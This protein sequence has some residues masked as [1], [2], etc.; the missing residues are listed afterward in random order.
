MHFQVL[1][2]GK[3]A[4]GAE[5]SLWPVAPAEAVVFARR[6]TDAAG[7]AVLAVPVSGELESGIMARATHGSK[8]ATRKFRFRR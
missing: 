1:D 8:S 7:N 4:L 6:I 5:V 2:S 3:A